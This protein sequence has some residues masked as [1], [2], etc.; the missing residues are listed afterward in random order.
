MNSEDGGWKVWPDVFIGSRGAITS[1]KMAAKKKSASK[2]IPA[3]A[4]L[5]R[6]K[7]R[8]SDHFKGPRQPRPNRPPLISYVFAFINHR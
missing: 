1:A 6:L 2:L 3:T 5:L 4:V 8:K 7:P